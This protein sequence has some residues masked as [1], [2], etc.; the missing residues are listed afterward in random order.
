MDREIDR[1]MVRQ[2]CIRDKRRLTFPASLRDH[3]SRLRL[4]FAGCASRALS[5]GQSMV[6]APTSFT[7]CPQHMHGTPVEVLRMTTVRLGGGVHRTVRG[8]PYHLPGITQHWLTSHLP[9][10]PSTSSRRP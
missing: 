6:V 5:L 7:A 8:M 1:E 9:P 3:H 4:T 10:I 2:V